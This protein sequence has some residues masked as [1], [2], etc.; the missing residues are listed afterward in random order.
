MNPCISLVLML[1]IVKSGS[2]PPP[3]TVFMITETGSYMAT[4]VTE[5]QMAL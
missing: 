3:S 4:E 1:N 2:I 5:I